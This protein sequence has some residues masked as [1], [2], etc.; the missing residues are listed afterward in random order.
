MNQIINHVC[1]WYD[2]DRKDL[3]GERRNAALVE[4]R[5]ASYW[6]YEKLTD[7]SYA[8]IGRI[9]HRDHTT[10][11][12]G[13]KKI[14]KEMSKGTTKARYMLDLLHHLENPNQL[15]LSI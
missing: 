6:L 12:Y 5:Q 3:L 2:V 13:C 7:Y 4:A 1:N 9:H 15:R 11:T 10:V 8:R 14:S